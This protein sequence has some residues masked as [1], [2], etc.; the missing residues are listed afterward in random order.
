[1]ELYEHKEKYPTE[2]ASGKPERDGTKTHHEK[3]GEETCFCSFA[4]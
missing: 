4:L 2:E 1:L 3:E